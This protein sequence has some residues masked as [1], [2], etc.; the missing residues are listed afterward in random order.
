MMLPCFCCLNLGR[1]YYLR[2][3]GRKGFQRKVQQF[4]TWKMP[5]KLF[6]RYKG[7]LLA[8]VFCCFWIWKTLENYLFHIKDIFLLKILLNLRL[9]NARK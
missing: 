7:H 4:C 9:G 1:G 3:F 8:W 5:E 6:I 2:N